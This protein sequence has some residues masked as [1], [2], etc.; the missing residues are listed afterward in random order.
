MP[1]TRV[2]YH[3]HMEQHRR[4]SSTEET[5]MNRLYQKDLR[6]SIEVTP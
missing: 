3:A 4:I 1:L 5:E 6:K 2:M